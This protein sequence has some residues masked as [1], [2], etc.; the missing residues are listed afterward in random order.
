MTASDAVEREG[1][2]RCAGI[3]FNE[4]IDEL[5]LR[6]TIIERLARGELPEKRLAGLPPEAHAELVQCLAEGVRE[7]VRESQCKSRVVH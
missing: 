6:L 7:A 2:L 3:S 1:R 5:L 4:R